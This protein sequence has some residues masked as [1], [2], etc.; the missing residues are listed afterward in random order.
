MRLL[1][2]PNPVGVACEKKSRYLKIPI[3]VDFSGKVFKS[4]KG[5]M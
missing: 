2:F 3:D 5:I 1:G 4:K